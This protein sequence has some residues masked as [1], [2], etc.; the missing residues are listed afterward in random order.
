MTLAE[1]IYIHI[2]FCKTKCPYCDFASWAKKEHIVEQYFD[3]LVSEIQSKCEAYHALLSLRGVLAMKQSHNVKQSGD[4]FVRA[5]ALPRN[6]SDKLSTIKTIFIGGGTPSLI[7]P[8]LYE[9]LFN[10]LKKYFEISK[11]CEVTLELNP[12]TARKDYLAGY[13]KLGINRI[14]IGAQSFNEKVLETLGRKHSV[15]DTEEAITLVKESGFKNFNLDLIYSVPEMTKEMWEETI[16]RAIEFSPDHIS[17]YS[18][19]IEPNTPFEIIYKDPDLLP[20]DDF[21][22]EFY[23]TLCKRLKD[24]GYIHY[25]I[26]NFA[27][28]GFECKHNL[29]YWQDEEYFAFG[30]SAH[31]YLNGL[32]TCNIRELEAYIKNPN[33]ET[34]LDFPLNNNFD[35][36][37][38][39]S[40]L[41]SGF[42]VSLI[43]QITHKSQAEVLKLLKSL[44]YEGLIELSGSKVH[45]TEKGMFV[46]NEILLKL[47]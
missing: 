4:C 36:V 22:F 41:K 46:N 27:K 15:H 6:D 43:E 31:R 19:I 17:A 12:G 20:P 34:I 44:S 39:G 16:N 30:V 2:P 14:S 10:E 18:L 3:S 32:R 11:D 7:H 33:L 23:L 1:S 26:S 8:D 35:K 25:E 29:C 9:K 42:D 38:L 21:A 40:R 5:K 47:I 45:L 37:M 13:K 28:G 24:S